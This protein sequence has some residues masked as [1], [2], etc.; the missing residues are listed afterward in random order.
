MA[1]VSAA[2]QEA[3]PVPE[4]SRFYGIV[5]AM[6]HNDHEPPHFHARYGEHKAIVSIGDASVL[7][8]A[9]P[10]RALGLVREWARSHHVELQEDWALARQ[11]QPLNPIEPLE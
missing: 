5:I 2:R 7:R 3:H 9:L 11:N 1:P 4:I 8:G 6:F 10:P